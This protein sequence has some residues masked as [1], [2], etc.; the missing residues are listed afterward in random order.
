MSLSN[1][2]TNNLKTL[3]LH[4]YDRECARVAIEDFIRDN[5]KM[6]NDIFLIVHGVGSGILKKMTHDTLKKHKYVVEYQVDF[7]NVGCTIVRIII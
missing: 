5:R 6:K 4:G 7:M 3:D 2:F 1:V